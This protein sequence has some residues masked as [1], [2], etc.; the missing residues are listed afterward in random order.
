MSKDQH[1]WRKEDPVIDESTKEVLRGG[2][3]APQREWWES[4][5]FIKA[6]ITGYG[7]GKTLIASKRGIALALHNAPSP[8]LMVSPSHRIA[9]KTV[10]ITLRELLEGKQELLGRRHFSWRYNKSDG[11]FTIFHN[12]RVGYIWIASGDTPESLK[13][14]N[15]GSANIDEPFIQDRSVFD[16]VIAR[17]R[18]PRAKVREIG[19]TGTPE[20]LN[21]GYDICEGE[22]KDKFDIDVVQA[23]SEENQALPETYVEG[24]RRA[25]TEQAAQSYVE[26]KFVSLSTGL[27]YYAFSDDNIVDLDFPYPTI[28]VGIGMDFNVDP[29]ALVAFWRHGDHIHVFE[30]LELD[31]SDTEYA[32]QLVREKFKD[33]CND[34]WPD[35]SGQA[36]HTS[37]PAGQSDFT[38]IRRY[39]FNIHA[40]STNPSRK[41]RYNAVNGKFSPGDGSDP[42]LTVA[43][44]CTKLIS[45]LKR[46]SYANMGKPLGKSMSHLLDAF[47][48]P[49][50]N[51]FPVRTPVVVRSLHG[52]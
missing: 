47:G 23:S 30:E 38:I 8:H 16:Q 11:E 26:G 34:V 15:I 17:V 22:E 48:Y 20:D 50:A 9:K 46:Y 49:V 45:Y 51:L 24:M 32:C 14:P 33:R 52:H 39:G 35:A 3:W 6:L 19:L 44:R 25:F 21:W 10:I 42:T 40:L 28:E 31:N 27:V 5:S 1:F 43:P 12:G 4:T 29:M 37:S 2:M 41:D 18:D 7:G 36:R 13:G